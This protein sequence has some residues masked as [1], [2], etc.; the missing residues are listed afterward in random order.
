LAAPSCSAAADSRLLA[1]ADRWLMAA[2]ACCCAV[3]CCA[4]LARS[5]ASFFVVLSCADCSREL[6][7]YFV[8]AF[9]AHCVSGGALFPI[10]VWLAFYSSNSSTPFSLI[11][12]LSMTFASRSLCSH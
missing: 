7:S 10:G 11:K 3:L 9:F 1:A 2:A 5:L 6:L 12:V 4:A 8:S